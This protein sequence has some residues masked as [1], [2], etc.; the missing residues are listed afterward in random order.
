MLP[1][2]IVALLP[3]SAPVSVG[4]MIARSIVINPAQWLIERDRLVHPQIGAIIFTPTPMLITTPHGTWKPSWMHRYVLAAAI[5]FRTTT[6]PKRETVF[7]IAR[8]QEV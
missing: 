8:L 2:I 3:R 6:H 1:Q 4:L 5:Q 7:T